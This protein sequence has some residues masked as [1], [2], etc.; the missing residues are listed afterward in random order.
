MEGAQNIWKWKNSDKIKKIIQYNTIQY[1]T[2]QYN[3]IQYNT[4]NIIYLCFE[5]KKNIWIFIVACNY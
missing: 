1:N 3:T 4:I 5:D 2:I